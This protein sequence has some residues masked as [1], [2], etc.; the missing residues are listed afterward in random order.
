[1]GRSTKDFSAGA[2]VNA[3][4]M[5]Y[6][7]I[8]GPSNFTIEKDGKTYAFKAEY[9]MLPD[10]TPGDGTGNPDNGGGDPVGTCEGVDIATIPVYPN[11]LKQTGRA[12]QVMLLAA[13]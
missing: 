5:Y 3:Q 1:M 2:T 4:V 9:P 13:I 12:T 10:A 11:F 8:T 7:P 6:M